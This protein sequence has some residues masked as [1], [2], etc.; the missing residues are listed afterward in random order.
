[1]PY[2]RALPPPAGPWA[3]QAGVVRV[4]QDGKGFSTSFLIRRVAIG[5]QALQLLASAPS[6]PFPLLALGLPENPYI[7]TR[8]VILW[9]RE[10]TTLHTD[11]PVPWL[12]H[13][14]P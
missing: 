11:F 3:W 13:I 8:L 7:R 10:I 12:A 5:A 1:M 6:V 2:V 14:G 9:L 4:C